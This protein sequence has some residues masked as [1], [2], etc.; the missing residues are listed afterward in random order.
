MWRTGDATA[1]VQPGLSA[2]IAPSS[3]LM[4]KLALVELS[5]GHDAGIASLEAD[6]VADFYVWANR[7]ER[8]YARWSPMAFGFDKPSV[9]RWYGARVE[10]D[11]ACPVCG[12][13]EIGGNID[14][15]FLDVG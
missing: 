10:R 3:T 8:T 15:L 13:R 7:R 4:V 6:L 5:R 11:P 2:D 14:P 1:T 9:L 12:S